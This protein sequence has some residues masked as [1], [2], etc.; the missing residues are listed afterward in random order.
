M[1]NR[2][3]KY[4]DVTEP[5]VQTT[6]TDQPHIARSVERTAKRVQ[7]M[8]KSMGIYYYFPVACLLQ[9]FHQKSLKHESVRKV[10]QKK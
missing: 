9:Y 8:L 2:T 1:E 3:Q 5:N 4:D 6:A 10:A 7:S